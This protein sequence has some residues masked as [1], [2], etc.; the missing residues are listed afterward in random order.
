MGVDVRPGKV[1]GFRIRCNK[2]D[3]RLWLLVPEH[4]DK[5]P[6]L[7]V[8]RHPD[9]TTPPPYPMPMVPAKPA[10]DD[11]LDLE[12]GDDLDDMQL[13][14]DDL[15]LDIPNAHDDDDD[16]TSLAAEIE[17]ELEAGMLAEASNDTDKHDASDTDAIDADQVAIDEDTQPKAS[18]GNGK[19]AAQAPR[20]QPKPLNRPVP[21]GD[22]L[23]LELD[24]AEDSDI[25]PMDDTHMPLGDPRR[26]TAANPK[27]KAA[28][29]KPAAKPVAPPAVKPPQ[30]AAPTK[31]PVAAQP[32]PPKAPPVAAKPSPSP[33]PQ[34]QAERLVL[35]DA[36][37]DRTA[38][39]NAPT[40]DD[41]DITMAS[42]SDADGTAAG[43]G[44]IA[45]TQNAAPADDA[46]LAPDSS[47]QISEA[48]LVD[49]PEATMASPAGVKASPK[50]A[51][52]AG[53]QTMPSVPAAEADE[54]TMV[55]A[56]GAGQSSSAAGRPAINR[57]SRPP[58]AVEMTVPSQ[59]GASASVVAPAQP[60]PSGG[61]LGRLGGY[62]LIRELGRGGMGSVFLA[63]QLSLDRDVAVK[64]MNE[65]W[66][67]NAAFVARFTREAYA[68][69]QLV[70][71]NV[72]Q[73]YDIGEDHDTNFFSME[74]VRG[75]SLGQLIR[76]QG[77]LD[78]EQA[79]GYILQAARG[80]RY[81]EQQ[82]MIHRDIKPDN[83]MLNDQGIVKVADLGL[84]KTPGAVEAEIESEIA[85]GGAQPADAH[86]SGL[87]GAS[88]LSSVSNVTR[89]DVAMGTPAYMAPEQ[90]R[91]A[92]NVDIRADIY[93]L[94]CTLYV[95]LTGKPVHEGKTAQ[96]LITKHATEPIVPPDVIS[97]HVPKELS[98][99]IQKMV[100]KDPASRYASMEQVIKALEDFLG[101][102]S[103]GPFTPREEHVK[104]LEQQVQNYNTASAAKLRRTLIG[105]FF[106]VSSLAMVGLAVFGQPLLVGAMIALMVLAAASYFV[107]TG[108][109]QKTFVFRKV[110][111]LVFGS[112]IVDWFIWTAG[113]VAVL[114]VL[115]VFGQLFIWVGVAVAAAVIALA[116]HIVI[117]RKVRNQRKPILEDAENLLKSMR[118]RGL[119]EDALRQFVC[120][121]SGDRWEA[122]YE[123][124][125]DYEAK[126]Q[127]RQKWGKGIRG[128]DRKKHG[129]WRD[130]LIAWIDER[131]KARKEA[132]ERK[133]LAKVQA[134]ELKAKGMT[135][136]EAQAK[137]EQE[138]NTMVTAA[139]AFQ[140]T[141]VARPQAVG[142]PNAAA[143]VGPTLKDLLKG[144]V[145]E[146]A[147]K[148]AK[149]RASGGKSTLAELLF[150]KRMRFVLAIVLIGLCT[151]WLHQNGIIGEGATANLTTDTVTNVASNPDGLQALQIPLVPESVTRFFSGVNTG[152][153]GLILLASVFMGRVKISLLILP[154]AAIAG[155]AHHTGLI[156]TD[157]PVVGSH[158]QY[159]AIAAGLIVA[160]PGFLFLRK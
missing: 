109:T 44:A 30:P 159:A 61:K 57:P 156:P 28:A 131:M 151:L 134:R 13:A 51:A 125:F 114:I 130:A 32:A 68:A 101:V 83:L 107:I 82:G 120:T 14:G 105:A 39:L 135:D 157:L 121:Y 153:A 113:F 47:T 73:I 126:I 100:D 85:A 10:A 23:D 71:H 93:S 26:S 155:F 59:G 148:R 80:L 72:V 2:C 96:E 35:G 112:S 91:D 108:V 116:F 4:R 97:K 7:A 106:G 24:S 115:Y 66:A 48:D 20:P 11:V 60:A 67:S 15:E 152:V 40:A 31:R 1:G 76:E 18:N 132:R 122:F 69:A 89:V 123:D 84:V 38:S 90:A 95:M 12:L 6:L 143:P 128:K 56:S 70:H 78:V 139:V 36:I 88:K 87:G 77:A 150:G 41:V 111:Q 21:A 147:Q 160:I 99:I 75:Q 3:G 146:A 94:G 138:A 34:P 33:K 158:T 86:R 117:D 110:R 103:A 81:A 8:V 46:T 17:A 149:A 45:A 54:H 92:K 19:P 142:V 124:L 37:G 22:V 145:D 52:P 58:G 104:R 27:P 127:A 118:L 64:T 144:D 50:P 65:Q 119:E 140:E 49:E 29:P 53:D 9:D 55:G 137:A 133:Y 141:M 62:E 79:V 98:A 16:L 63:R 74:F 154:A 129:P 102:E 43:V 42:D 5:L 25:I 136:K